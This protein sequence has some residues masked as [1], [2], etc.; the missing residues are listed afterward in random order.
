MRYYT[1]EVLGYG[2]IHLPEQEMH[3]TAYW[4]FLDEEVSRQ[5]ESPHRGSNWAT[6]RQRARERDGFACQV[7]GVSEGVAGREHDVHH[8]IPFREFG[9]LPGVNDSYLQA[10]QL[11]NLITLCR[12]CH[13]RVSGDRLSRDLFANGWRGLAHVLHDLAPLY[14]MCEPQN[15][16]VY[17]ELR[18]PL[19]GK[20]TIY[21]Y[22]KVP[23]GV[24][25]GEAL[26]ELHSELLERAY[27]TV[28]ECAC[29][30]G[31]PSCVGPSAAEGEGGK[32]AALALLRR[33]LG[34]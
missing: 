2:D 15:L 12:S 7:C 30:D 31:C 13:Q 18:S 5:V 33:L 9:S 6:Q 17:S 20:P 11:D 32:G 24:G 16:G 34:R 14:L 1:R 28:E 8:I 19:T 27:E 23:A 4:L 10:N 25:F 26:F 22:D 21:I 29:A 3:T